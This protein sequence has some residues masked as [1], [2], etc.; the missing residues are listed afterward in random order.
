MDNIVGG[1]KKVQEHAYTTLCIQVFMKCGDV[2]TFW[3]IRLK[4]LKKYLNVMFV[5]KETDDTG[6][7]PFFSF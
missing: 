7:M 4:I 2:K 1:D 6:I 5:N 3:C